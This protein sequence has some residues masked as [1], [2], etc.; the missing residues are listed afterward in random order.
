LKGQEGSSNVRALLG[1]LFLFAVSGLA[2]AAGPPGPLLDKSDPSMIRWR[3]VPASA[4]RRKLCSEV[5]PLPEAAKHWTDCHSGEYSR[6]GGPAECSCAE[7]DDKL[8]WYHCK[9]GDYAR[10]EDDA[11]CRAGDSD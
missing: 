8:V 5:Y 4:P 10:C 9:E 1:V 6:C 11:L 3:L 2:S 7:A